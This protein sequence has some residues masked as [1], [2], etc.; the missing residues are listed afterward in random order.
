MQHVLFHDGSAHT[1]GLGAKWRE[2]KYGIWLALRLNWLLLADRDGHTSSVA[3][4][5]NPAMAQNPHISHRSMM[6][7]IGIIGGGEPV[8]RRSPSWL[9][10]AI[11]AGEYQKAPPLL[12][13]RSLLRPAASRITSA[14]R[15]V[16][17][18]LEEFGSADADRLTDQETASI[19]ETEALAKIR[20]ATRPLALFFT[21]T[22][23]PL[24]WHGAS[25]R[26]L[27]DAFVS[28]RLR[29]AVRA[30]RH[31]E[32]QLPPGVEKSRYLVSIHIREF[33]RPPD[34]ADHMASST[35]R[36][37]S[38]ARALNRESQAPLAL[39]HDH[40]G[41]ATPRPHRRTSRGATCRARTSS[42]RSR[43]SSQ[44]R[45]SPATTPPSS[46]SALATRQPS[47]RSRHTPTTSHVHAPFQK[48][49][50]KNLATPFVRTPL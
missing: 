50:A 48:N 7:A 41:Q 27:H 34:A 3:W 16:T 18:D 36:S 20:S 31:E 38:A 32:L 44:P 29:R 35:P 9:L 46:P 39:G 13:P 40:L 17:I 37:P 47:A 1:E 33:V 28:H 49:L 21:N 43:R 19:L 45:H 22:W 30:T 6:G 11:R 12:P 4:V 25:G 2:F 5:P 24:E 14:L 42:R 10:G 8:L 15:Q 26:W 23:E